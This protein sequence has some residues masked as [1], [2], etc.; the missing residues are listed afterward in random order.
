MVNFEFQKFDFSKQKIK[1]CNYYD[2]KLNFKKSSRK[3][4]DHSSAIAFSR[5]I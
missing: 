5:I 4:S 3:V 2:I 1:H